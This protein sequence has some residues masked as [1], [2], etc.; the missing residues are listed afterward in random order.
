MERL[1]FVL[2]T[3]EAV[4]R[5]KEQL[6]SKIPRELRREDY[7]YSDA[8]QK[9][10][11][12]HITFQKKGVRAG[13]YSYE[14]TPNG[15]YICV[16][17]LRELPEIAIE[18]PKKPIF[19]DTFEFYTE[20]PQ[21]LNIMDNKVEEEF[22]KR[23]FEIRPTTGRHYPTFAISHQAIAKDGELVVRYNL[24]RNG[25][26]YICHFSSMLTKEDYEKIKDLLQEWTE[27]LFK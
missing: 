24:E 9:I 26:D 20:T 15:T 11:F 10:D 6:E 12:Y 7:H 19:S 27:P 23:G 18:R 4:E 13:T 2:D 1:E 16:L 25:N 3:K 14:L 5:F 21:F 22:K 17:D 8:N